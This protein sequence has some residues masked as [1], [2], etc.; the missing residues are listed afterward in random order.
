MRLHWVIMIIILLFLANCT[1]NDKASTG[2]KN[3][4]NLVI[5]TSFYPVYI[6]LLNL[7][8]NTTHVEVFSLAKSTTGCLHDYQLTPRDMKLLEKADCLVI[9]GAGMESYLDR[10][11][12]QFPGLKIIDPSVGIPILDNDFGGGK[13]PH[14]W[15]NINYYVKQVNNIADG[16]ALIDPSNK[17]HYKNNSVLYMKKLLQ[18]R[19]RMHQELKNLKNTNIITFHDAFGYFARE[20][21]LNVA[22]VM[23]KEGGIEPSARELA[24]IIDTIKKQGIQVVFSEPQYPVKTPE[25]IAKETGVK[26]FVLDP[27]V[28]GT[29]NPDAY[30]TTMETNLSILKEALK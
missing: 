9:N 27:I 29:D 13:N 16:L 12:R 18:F 8:K 14:Y 23:E 24:D 1:K 5:L 7:T 4:K 6:T 19:T 26:I 20:F 17:F 10:I 28:T 11:V 21:G 15:V 22:G 3:S 2:D 30:L 25:M